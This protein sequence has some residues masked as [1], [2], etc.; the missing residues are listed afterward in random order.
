[1]AER[2]G[3]RRIQVKSWAGLTAGTER[4]LEEVLHKVLKKSAKKGLIIKTECMII[5]KRNS[6]KCKLQIRDF[7]I[8]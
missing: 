2:A 5:G 6:L 1:M 7:S 4:K 8:K 3:S